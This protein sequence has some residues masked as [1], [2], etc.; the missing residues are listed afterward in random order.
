MNE[1]LFLLLPIAA[2][3]GWYMGRRS[4]AQSEKTQR[5]D[6]SEKYVAGLNYLLSDQADKAVDLFIEMIQV[7]SET[8]DTHLALASLFRR[9]GEVERAIKLHQNLVQ[10]PNITQEQRDLAFYE[11]GQDFMMAGLYDRAEQAYLELID[12]ESFRTQALNQLLTIYESMREWQK[13][14]NIAEKHDERTRLAPTIAHYYCQ[15]ATDYQTAKQLKNARKALNNALKMDKQ[16]VRASYLLA[17]LAVEQEQLAEAARWFMRIFHQDPEF[18]PCFLAEMESCIIAAEG[19]DAWMALLV[20]AVE[21]SAGAS[22]AIRLSELLCEQDHADQA[23]QLMLSQLQR[24]PTLKGFHHYMGFHIERA[25]AGHARDSLQWLRGLVGHQLNDK[26]KFQCRH[27][28]YSGNYLHW[29]CPSC[30]SWG[31]I[32]PLRGLDGE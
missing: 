11:L 6:F 30:K 8:I 14:I 13:A 19:E 12:S 23:E 25:E 28:G 1:L 32:K 18:M 9:R 26:P 15:L 29:Q 21:K 7:D 31:Q 3:Y 5:Q 4:A 20:E 22:V 17:K 2:G 10:R 24:A 16:C 27:C